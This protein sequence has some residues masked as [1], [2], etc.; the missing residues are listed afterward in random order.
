LRRITFGTQ[1]PQLRSTNAGRACST[2]RAASSSKRDPRVDLDRG[3]LIV[4]CQGHPAAP[5]P[6]V[7]EH[8]LDPDELGHAQAGAERAAHPAK[9]RIGHVLHRRQHHG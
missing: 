3:R 8:L 6:R 1:Q 2:T 5:D 4:V 7:A 9:P